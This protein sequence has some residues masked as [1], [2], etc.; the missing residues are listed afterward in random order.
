MNGKGN[1]LYDSMNSCYVKYYKD[2]EPAY[3]K[4]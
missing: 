1:F 3:K 2:I 4:G